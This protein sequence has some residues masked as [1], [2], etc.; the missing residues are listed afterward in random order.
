MIVKER[1]LFDW[2]RKY[3]GGFC[4]CKC[5]PRYFFMEHLKPLIAKGFRANFFY[6]FFNPHTA[7]ELRHYCI[8]IEIR[9]MGIT[10]LHKI[11][12]P[13]LSEDLLFNHTNTTMKSLLLWFLLLSTLPP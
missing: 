11:K 2:E 3:K 9:F 12:S 8:P 5:L 7:C 4:F 10:D 13:R 6:Y 1:F